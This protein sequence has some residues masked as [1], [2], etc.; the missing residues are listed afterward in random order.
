MSGT[1]AT[2]DQL[3]VMARVLDAYCK[4][5]GIENQVERETIAAQIVALFETG[6]DEEDELMA[7]LML[8][9]ASKRGSGGS[10][11]PKTPA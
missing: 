11:G 6:I 7:A 3:A 1:M 9:A 5:A 2:P 10:F 4:L 8:P